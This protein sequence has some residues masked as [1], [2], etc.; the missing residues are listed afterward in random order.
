MSYATKS[1]SQRC[2]MSCAFISK[3]AKYTILML[4]FSI[5]SWHKMRTNAITI[6]VVILHEISR[7]VFLWQKQFMSVVVKWQRTEFLN[8][9]AR[10]C[11]C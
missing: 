8:R 6:T 11:L 5:V 4:I 1:D 9:K 3:T 7:V 2:W 10:Q